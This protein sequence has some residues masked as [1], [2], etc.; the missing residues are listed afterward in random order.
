MNNKILRFEFESLISTVESINKGKDGNS[1]LFSENFFTVESPLPIPKSDINLSDRLS[2]KNPKPVV[3]DKGNRQEIILSLLKKNK[4]LGIKD[5]ATS[6]SGCSEK[7]IQRELASLVSK[8]LIT[9]TGEKRWSKY[10]LK[11]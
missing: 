6:I 8:G 10:S 1:L 11:S 7:T 3:K 5:F 2:F 4:D 9:K